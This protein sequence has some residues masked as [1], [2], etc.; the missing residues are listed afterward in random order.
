LTLGLVDG[1]G[2]C[3]PR[4]LEEVRIAAEFAR[5]FPSDSDSPV[6]TKE[7]RKELQSLYDLHNAPAGGVESEFDA[8]CLE[9]PC[10]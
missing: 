7:A 4:S 9:V 2:N 8:D 3:A 10:V 1:D 6:Y 5:L